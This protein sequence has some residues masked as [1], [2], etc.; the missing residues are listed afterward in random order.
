MNNVVDAALIKLQDTFESKAVLVF[1]EIEHLPIEHPEVKEYLSRKNY[2]W[3][4]VL[5]NGDVLFY[6]D[7]T[8]ADAQA[9]FSEI[10]NV[11]TL[12]KSKSLNCNL[13]PCSLTVLNHYLKIAS[14]ETE[15]KRSHHLSI[16]TDETSSEIEQRT[17]TQHL[18][19]NI[20]DAAYQ[21]GSSDIHIETDEINNKSVFRFRVDGR[22]IEQKAAALRL[23]EAVVS[24]VASLIIGHEAH[25]GGGS[26]SD[27]FDKNRPIGGSFTVKTHRR[28][29]KLRYSHM[30]TSEPKG[31]SIVMRIVTGDGNGGIPTFKDLDYSIGEIKL[32][33]R[34]LKYPNGIV[35]FTGPT[36]SGKSSAMAAGT[37][38]FPDTVKILAFED[39]VET[40]LPN[41]CQ[42]Q[43]GSSATT[44]FAAYG[45]TA[46][47]QD[48]DVIIYGEIRD[49][50]VMSSAIDQA[51]TGH[52]VLTTLHTNTPA[53]AIERLLS[54]GANLTALTH[55]S[56]IRA[57]VGQRLIPRLCKHCKVSLNNAVKSRW[58]NDDHKRVHNYFAKYHPEELNGIYTVNKAGNVCSNCN[59]TGEKGRAPIVEIIHVDNI[60]RG[61][62]KKGDINGWIEHLR[63]RNWIDLRGK[64]LK[65]IFAGQ[66]CALSTELLI[67]SPFGISNDDFDY[68]QFGDHL[69]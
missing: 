37:T 20:I 31:L 21:A 30:P 66:V 1:T 63:E 51:N 58:A 62:I 68:S 49:P 14:P 27:T 4:T 69:L 25:V 6:F 7:P 17:N 24:R 29:V 11:Q 34:I 53:D 10:T 57:I 13:R 15:V 52:L 55:S 56:L 54:L 40:N 8:A 43:V 26:T 19:D 61:Y 42:V 33:N 59:H 39:P 23:S 41:V 16:V 36:G 38:I 22:L 65:R 2:N 9:Y 67:E 45:R 35:F 46:L 3:L 48:P 64:A 60:G 5:D 47:R 50:E 32:M 18:L 12:M 44:N 28:T